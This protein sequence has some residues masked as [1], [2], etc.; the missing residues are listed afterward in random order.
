VAIACVAASACAAC[1]VA[2]DNWWMLGATLSL[3]PMMVSRGRLG[4]L[5]GAVL[6]AV[7]AIS[8]ARLL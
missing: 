2:S 6:L 4:R 7:Y 5:E 8:L 3:F 1:I